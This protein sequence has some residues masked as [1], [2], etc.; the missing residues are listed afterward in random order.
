LCT[1]G[2]AVY[3]TA[4]SLP[5]TDLPPLAKSFIRLAV[6]FALGASIDRVEREELDAMVTALEHHDGIESAAWMVST[7]S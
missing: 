6:A 5:A 2:G 3:E 4:R 7:T 1:R